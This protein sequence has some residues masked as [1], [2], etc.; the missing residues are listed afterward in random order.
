MSQCQQLTKFLERKKNVD[1]DHKLKNFAGSGGVLLWSNY[2]EARGCFKGGGF[3]DW[4]SL[5]VN[6]QVKCFG[7][8]RGSQV[9]S[10]EGKKSPSRESWVQFHLV[11]QRTDKNRPVPAEEVGDLASFRGIENAS[12]GWTGC[13]TQNRV[14]AELRRERRADE[15]S[16]KIRD[17]GHLSLSLENSQTLRKRR[18]RWWQLK[19]AFQKHDG[20]RFQTNSK[21]GR[22]SSKVF[23]DR[24]WVSCLFSSR[25]NSTPPSVW[26]HP[27]LDQRWR[28][29]TSFPK[30]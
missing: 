27:H 20:E 22:Y 1:L 13:F 24:Y 30:D 25:K 14:N 4:R 9:E 10:E 19:I 28:I 6:L 15:R 26:V 18:E 2:S 21:S 23:Q 17:F 7:W 8:G 29:I 11:Q 5:G 16:N 12:T 3:W